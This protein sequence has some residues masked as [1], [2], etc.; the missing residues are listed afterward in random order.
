MMC[1]VTISAIVDIYLNIVYY[2]FFFSSR[3]RHTSCALVTG[4]QTCALPIYPRDL[5]AG[6]D[7]QGVGAGGGRRAAPLRGRAADV[8]DAK[9]RTP[10]ALA[11]DDRDADPPHADA[12]PIWRDGSE[13]P[14]R[15]EIGRAHV[16]T[17]VTNAHLVCRLLLEKKNTI[18]HT[19]TQHN[20]KLT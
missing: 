2:F 15:D 12:D 10:A 18:Q 11:G 3:R 20:N 17:P 6:S 13:P 4:V 19:N 8:A 16:C 5:S 1:H 9:G 7:L 14:R